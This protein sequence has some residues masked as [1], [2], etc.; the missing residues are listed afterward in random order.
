MSIRILPESEIKQA[1]SSF[2]N[3]PLLFANPKNLYERRAKRLRKLAE[4]HPFSDYLLFVAEIVDSQLSVLQKQPLEQ[5][6]RLL[7]ENLS[8]EFLA[9]HPLDVEKWQ[10]DQHWIAILHALLAEMKTKSNPLALETI[11]WLEKASNDDLNQRAKQ[12]LQQDVAQ[13]SAD[14][15]VFIWAALSL[16]W[17]QLAQQLP[18]TSNAESGEGLHVCPV[19]RSAPVASV[20]HFGETQGLRYLHCSLCES[21][22]NMVRAKCSNCD[23]AQHLDY[24]SINQELAAVR[25]ESC[26]DCHSYLK[27]LFQD[28]DPQVEAVADDLAQIFLD[29]EMEEKG[30]ARSGLNPFMFPNESA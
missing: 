27:I 21:E 26:G 28:K 18:H 24:W 5:D 6:P 25:A 13:V 29:I 30:F 22:W 11:D 7:K 20:V 10:L 16:Y 4:N 23:Q 8:A 12:L 19:C 9:T 15:A 2:Q 17:V 3:P 1:A 14:Q